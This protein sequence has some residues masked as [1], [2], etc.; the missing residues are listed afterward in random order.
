MNETAKK[1]LLI[2][3]AVAAVAVAVVVGYRTLTADQIRPGLNNDLPPGSKTGKQ[4]E[5][6]AMR[7]GGGGAKEEKDLGGDAAAGG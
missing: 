6:E 5:M 1:A 2:A 3:I 4:R 7:G